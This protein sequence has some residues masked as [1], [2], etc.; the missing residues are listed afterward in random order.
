MFRDGRAIR[1]REV[2]HALAVELDELPDDAL[3]A[4]HLGHRE[5]RVRRRGAL[6]ELARQLEANDLRQQHADRLTQHR[7]LR[8]DAA[9][10]PAEHAE[11]VDHRR[12]RVGADE[13]IGIRDALAVRV[14]RED[15]T[16]QVLEVDLVHDT[17]A[18]R[19]DAHVFERALPP[20]EELI[21][22]LVAL[23]LA[24]HVVFEGAQQ[25]I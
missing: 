8:F 7:R 16:R 14:T 4:K 20:L 10:A 5:N 2:L 17:R 21:A 9:H 25:A 24:L 6:G 23:E 22:L 3:L 12:V 15:D 19:H 18:R 1:K 11:T 13:A